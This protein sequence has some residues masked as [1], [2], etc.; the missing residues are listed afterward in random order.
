MQWITRF[1]VNVSGGLLALFIL[2]ACSESGPDTT[3]PA[4]TDPVES[5]SAE[6]SPSGGDSAGLKSDDIDWFDG[7]LD[8]AFA[9]AAEAGKP[10]FLYWGAEWC[11]PCHAISATV[12][13]DPQFIERSRLFVPVYLDGD[14]PDAQAAGEKFR[15]RGYPTMIVFDSDG[16][17]LTRIPGG[18]DLQAY[19]SILDLTLSNATP[20]S[21]LVARVVAGT[22]GVSADDCRRLA[23]Y[24]WG[25]DSEILEEHARADAFRR[26]HA[27]CP[28]S[29]ADERAAL[30]LNSLEAA[31][32][33]AGEDEEPVPAD[34]RPAALAE[35]E[36]IAASYEQ[37]KANALSMI[38]SGA[39]IVSVLTEADSARR[40]ALVDDLDAF[41]DRL[42][43]DDSVY[44]RE[45]IYAL[46]GKLSLER[47]DDPEADPSAGLRDEILAT[48]EWADSTTP[49]AWERQ[50]IINALGNLL[51]SAGMDDVARP[52]L[53]AEL[54]ISKQ[55]YYF[56]VGLADI[57]QRAGNHDAAMDWLKKAWDA[58]RGPA[59]RFQWGYYYLAGL[60]EMRPDDEQLIHDTTLRLITELQEGSGFYLRPKAQLAR[61]ETRLYD[62]SDSLGNTDALERIRESILG[63]CAAEPGGESRATCES[64]LDAA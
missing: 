20:V 25:Q 28:E 50:P 17:E 47:I 26:M 55:P 48:V 36:S 18:I 60:L 34:A 16:T 13:R 63:V 19:S 29:L 21:D 15:V 35:F 30:F 61:L 57:E 24:S 44:K 46:A 45:R 62:W 59:T 9:A 40:S 22:D 4:E 12:F 5:A 3:V 37:S 27:A 33:D 51:D 54:D 49:G 39:D 32:A 41:Y 7:P 31:I 11:P 43:A 42:A 53:L 64:F 52:L 58:S 10:I 56:M 2:A 38:F 23:W 8:A 6:S 1:A 14:Q